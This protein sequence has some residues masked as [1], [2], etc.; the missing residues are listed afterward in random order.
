LK[1]FAAHFYFLDNFFLRNC[2]LVT[3]ENFFVND[4]KRFG[5][6]ISDRNLYL[7][8]ISDIEKKGLSFSLLLI[9]F[10]RR[11]KHFY[12][13]VLLLLKRE[14]RKIIAHFV[15]QDLIQKKYFITK[16]NTNAI[17]RDVRSNY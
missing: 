7:Y 14:L 5:D 10:L 2:C 4:L 11:F 8:I 3:V 1:A 15:S 13:R 17:R 9:S 16:I 12:L 6:F